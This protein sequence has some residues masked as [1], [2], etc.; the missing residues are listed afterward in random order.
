[1][2]FLVVALH[3]SHERKAFDCGN[4][5]LN[6][7]FHRQANQDV[8]RKLS[9]CFVNADESRFVKGYYT[10]SNSSLPRDEAPEYFRR[11][12]PPSY[13]NLPVTLL[14]RLAIDVTEKGKGIGKLL[15]ADALKRSFIASKTIGSLAVVVDPIDEAATQFYTKFGFITLPDSGKMFLPMVTIGKLF[16]EL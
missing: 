7:Y 5:Q 4:E 15:V 13:L 3:S 14:G 1:M 10:L 2:G 8:K 9:V 16:P 12:L 6:V 11:K